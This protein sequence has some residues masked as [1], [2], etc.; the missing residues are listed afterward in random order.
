MSR[1]AGLSVRSFLTA[2]VS[3]AAVS[4]VALTP[5]I[6]SEPARVAVAP[7]HM[8]APE[9]QL[10]SAGDT[11]IAGYNAIQPWVAYGFQLADYALSF[12]PGLWWIAPAVD[13]AYYTAQ[14]VVQSLVY[15]F[16]YLLDGNFT[17]IGPTL[18]L[19]VQ[20]AVNNFIQYG[21]AWIG[22]LVPLP[23]LPPLP[24]VP[25]AAVKSPAAARGPRAAAAV[26]AADAVS[27]A[28]P[29]TVAAPRSRRDAARSAAP[30]PR[31]TAS[32]AAASAD[33]AA[34][35]GTADEG[36]KPSAHKSRHAR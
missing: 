31:P 13:L 7:I 16:A 34:T 30:A 1:S 32:A 25:G 14:P 29:V 36:V 27:A 18:T 24:P 26:V 10:A 5:L 11:I 17:A 3:A 19:G 35:A 15:S 9:I 28:A 21:I 20:N 33:G 8:V 12:V 23:P 2:G 6:I 4:A 22:S